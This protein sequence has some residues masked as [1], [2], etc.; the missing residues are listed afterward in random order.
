[1]EK[2]N[3]VLYNLLSDMHEFYLYS[4][5]SSEKY[6]KTSR[7]V[8]SKI[9][10]EIREPLHS[11]FSQIRL[12]ILEGQYGLIM[13]EGE[14]SRLPRIIIE[15]TVGKIHT[16][17]GYKY[18]KVLTDTFHDLERPEQK[19][20]TE[21]VSETLDDRTHG[22]RVLVVTEYIHSGRSIERYRRL[23]KI[24]VGY[25]VVS[26]F[27]RD[28][29]GAY[30][31]K[32][33]SLDNLFIGQEEHPTPL[34]YKRPEISSRA[35]HNAPYTIFKYRNIKRD[36]PPAYDHSFEDIRASEVMQEV[37]KNAQELREELVKT[38]K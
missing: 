29:K 9:V 27:S 10:P 14:S 15:H 22:K 6:I 25:D 33:N 35:E 17:Y 16:L 11:L 21:T 23:E 24:G 2:D 3:Q 36:G 37:Y 18:P 1:M 4:P 5:D 31:G 13:E 32:I 38:Y 7:E 28:R 34:L 30:S 19:P 26:L 8:V 12:N 20:L